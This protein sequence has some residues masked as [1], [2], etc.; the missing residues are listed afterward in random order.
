MHGGGGP[1]AF[2]AAVQGRDQADLFVGAV[3]GRIGDRNRVDG[4]VLFGCAGSFE[5][6]D[7]T[8]FF[9]PVTQRGFVLGLCD[10]MDAIRP[11]ARHAGQIDGV[12][13][14]CNQRHWRSGEDEG[15]DRDG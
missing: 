8:V 12:V 7:V 15:S 3:C 10:V 13:V 6:E 2:G 11:G 5:F 4:D 9:A 14:G 1:C